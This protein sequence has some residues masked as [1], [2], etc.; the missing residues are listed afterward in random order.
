M[1]NI[2]KY[3]NTEVSKMEENKTPEIYIGYVFNR[4]GSCAIVVDGRDI[5]KLPEEDAKKICDW[6]YRRTK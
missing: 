2:E 4:D 6:Y 5:K 3:P 1:K